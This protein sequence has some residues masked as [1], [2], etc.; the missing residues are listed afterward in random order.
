MKAPNIFGLVV[1]TLGLL[2]LL[3]S[4]WYLAFAIAFVV[5]ALHDAGHE[6]DASVYF[7][8][9]IPGFIVGL[10]LLRFGRIVVRFSYPNEKEDSEG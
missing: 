9:G 2:V 3:W 10:L 1:R 7:T 6:S 5:R 4:V 8:T